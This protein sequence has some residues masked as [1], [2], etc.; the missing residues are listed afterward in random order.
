LDFLGVD[1]VSVDM[2]AVAKKSS[3]RQTGFIAQEVEQAAKELG[4]DFSG[5]DI[6]E[7]ENNHYGLRY[8]QFVVPLVKAAQEQQKMIIKLQHEIEELK[9]SIKKLE[10]YY[11]L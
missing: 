1:R 3:I 10:K 8:S 2:K 6:P 9:S 5:V 4:F 7:N 11:Q